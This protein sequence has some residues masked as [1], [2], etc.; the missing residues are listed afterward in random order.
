MAGSITS[1]QRPDV[2]RAPALGVIASYG[3]NARVGPRPNVS[4]L[5]EEAA[6]TDAYLSSSYALIKQ[7]RQVV[8]ERIEAP[9]SV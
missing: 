3:L 7:L 5:A 1:L 9:A 4:D 6:A 8:S 2:R